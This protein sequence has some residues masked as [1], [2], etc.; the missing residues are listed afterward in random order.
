MVHQKRL[1]DVLSDFAR[2]LT[3]EYPVQT[4]LDDFVASLPR[5]VPVTGAGVLL[6]GADQDMHFVAASDDVLLQ[7]ESLQIAYSEGPCLETYRCGE[8]VLIPDLAQDSRFPQFSPRARE[9][10]LAAV[11][12]FPMSVDDHRL[13]ALDV[14]RRTPGAL[15][16]ADVCA[17]QLLADV[18]ASY[19]TNARSRAASHSRVELLRQQTLHDPL[20]G[21]PNRVLLHDRLEQAIAKGRRSQRRLAVLFID[22]DGFK[23]INDRYGHQVGD[24]VL[25]AVAER[26]GSVLRP[27]DTLARLGGDEFVVLCEDLDHTA[28]AEAV[29]ARMAG[30]LSEPF[31]LPNGRYVLVSASIG[32]AYAG[33]GHQQLDTILGAADAAM[34]QAKEQ[35]G[36]RYVVTP[37]LAPSLSRI[38]VQ[39]SLASHS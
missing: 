3:H 16:S 15:E 11:F 6:M 19:V 34:Y 14:W 39:Q 27:A 26:L 37:E 22:L 35:G 28:K 7:V 38:P 9:A 10:G 31:R 18:A 24:D 20:T 32:V 25:I 2:T 36:G 12:A 29:A 30:A 33:E 4:I 23:S 5:V 8:P 1:T 13:G 17:V 21:L